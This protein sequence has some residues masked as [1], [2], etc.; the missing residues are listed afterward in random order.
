MK[1]RYSHLSS[2]MIYLVFEP[3]INAG[4]Y[5]FFRKVYLYNRQAVPAGRPV[6]LASNHPT[7]FL[8][9]LLHCCLLDPP[10][11][12][13]TRGD[14]FKK[15]FFRKLMEQ[16]NMFPVYR[17]RDGFQGRNRNDEVFD[18]CSDLLRRGRAI[19]IF[20]EGEHHTDRRILPIRSGILSVAF[21]AFEQHRLDE[22]RIVPAGF[23]YLYG[24]RTRDEVLITLGEPLWVRDYWKEYQENAAAATRRMRADIEAALRQ[25]SLHVEDTADDGLADQLLALHRADHPERLLPVFHYTNT[26][27]LEE[28][29]VCD[30]LNGLTNEQKTHL[31]AAADRYFSALDD[32]GISDV[33]LVNPRQGSAAWLLFLVPAFFVWLAGYVSSFPF[34]WLSGF[35][36]RTR[37][38]KQ[39][40]YSSVLFSV[41]VLSSILYYGLLALAGILTWNPIWIAAGLSLPLLGWFSLLYA[42]VWA[43]WRAARKARM[44]P[45][46]AEL[47]ALR[48]VISG[49]F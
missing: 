19:N 12:N 22:L 18:R 14:I 29:A 37:V 35:V 3:F 24:D 17:K 44:H 32:A 48:A 30:R 26:R 11:Y 9:P 16:A 4:F 6:I 43:R 40:Y 15:P 20:V 2:G 25:V 8:D 31:R 5:A 34:A 39:E 38:K 36:A 46:R 1:F 27:F 10:I 7:A 23:T 21:E 45:R 47:L 42:D 33:G 28:K 41:G 13:M 49:I